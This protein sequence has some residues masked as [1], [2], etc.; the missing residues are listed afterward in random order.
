MPSLTS[1]IV[2]GNELECIGKNALKNLPKLESLSLK[3]NQLKRWGKAFPPHLPALK[4]LDL[5]ENALESKTDFTKMEYYPGLV[6]LSMVGNPG[7]D[8]LGD[9]K[10]EILI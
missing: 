4:K 3:T 10:K 5:S 6:S 9:L 1:L 8:E 2:E 7:I